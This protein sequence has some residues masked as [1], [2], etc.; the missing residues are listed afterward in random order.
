MFILV[1][2]SQQELLFGSRIDRHLF[3]LLFIFIALPHLYKENQHP[4][5]QVHIQRKREREIVTVSENCNCDQN[6]RLS[7]EVSNDGTMR[8]F[9][10]KKTDWM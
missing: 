4:S 3:C 10:C 9:E 8:A 1:I 2:Q 5:T 6:P 7:F